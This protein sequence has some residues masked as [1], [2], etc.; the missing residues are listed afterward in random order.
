MLEALQLPFFRTAFLAILVLA[1]LHAYLG[2]HVVRRGVIFVDLA[3]AQMAALGF[4]LGVVL[5][6]EDHPLA[7]WLFPF[8]MTLVGAATFAWL[9]RQE[10]HVPLE[11]FIGIIFATAQAIVFLMLEKSPAGPEHLKETLVGSLFTVDPKQVVTYRINPKAAWYDGTPI[12]WEDF[13][14]QWKAQN[15]SNK[16]FRIASSNG[17]ADVEN[18]QRGRDDREVIVTFKSRFAD[19]QSIFFPVY[20][21][22]TTRD[23]KVFND[24]W[25]ERPLTTAGPF[26][27]QSIDR[28]TQTIT[29]VRNE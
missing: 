29:F 19:W 8:A 6:L 15:G 3:L 20:P 12:T 23:P 5:G 13:H 28:A 26:K 27:L 21:A 10:R 7:A 17:Y 2:Y 25:K 1:G 18:V 11:A 4:A 22:S 14:S 9:R 24:G 16:A